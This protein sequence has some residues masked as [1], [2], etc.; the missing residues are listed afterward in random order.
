M[1]LL[2]HSMATS[3]SARGLH[4]SVRLLLNPGQAFCSNRLTT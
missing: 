2:F 1:A 4:G 3:V